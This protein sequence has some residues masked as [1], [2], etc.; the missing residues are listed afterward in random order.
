MTIGVHNDHAFL[1]TDLE[2]AA[3]TYECSDCDARFTKSTNLLRHAQTCS[4]GQTKIHCDGRKVEAP[5]SLYERAFY[6]RGKFG[7]KACC[8]IEYESTKC[9]IHIH[10]HLCGCGGERVLAGH[11]I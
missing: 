10:H 4:K 9:G 2:K 7:K 8:W 6:P 11:L 5:D 3:K 1:I